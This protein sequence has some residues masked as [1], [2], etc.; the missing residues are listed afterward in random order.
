MREICVPKNLEM[1]DYSKKITRAIQIREFQASDEYRKY[2]KLR[3]VKNYMDSYYYNYQQLQRVIIEFTKASEDFSFW[4]ID[5]KRNRILTALTTSLYNYITYARSCVD[6]SKR[7]I[8]HLNSQSKGEFQ[9]V[10]LIF[11][12]KKEFLFLS[13]LRNS[14]VHYDYLKVFA[15]AKVDYL[16]PKIKS[17]I[18][19]KTEI[20]LQDK[21]LSSD[22]KDFLKSQ[23]IN[24]DLIPI[25][26]E[27]H[28]E[29][30]HAQ[31]V[32][33]R[34]IWES[35]IELLYPILQNLETLRGEIE[36]EEKFRINFHLERSFRHLKYILNS[37][38][39]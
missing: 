10:T 23:G 7:Y 3:M 38:K 11:K 34:L 28:T 1:R 33:R 39:H 25:L 8:K 20:L 31:S 4:N 36:E 15:E 30:T 35:N 21:E 22:V 27:F 9:A 26:K 16:D 13:E 32:F 37:I 29:F 12:D 2:L 6:Y 18:F 24:I 5:S 19:L 17:H 14:V